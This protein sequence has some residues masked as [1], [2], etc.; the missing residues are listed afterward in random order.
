MDYIEKRFCYTTPTDLN[1]YYCG[2]RTKTRNHS[3]GPQV[4]DHF[5]LV[6]IKE[7]NATLTIGDCCYDLHAGQLLCMFPGEK[8]YYKVNDC[9]WSNLWV[10]VYGRQ[11]DYYLQNLGI[12]RKYPIFNCPQPKETEKIIDEIIASAEISNSYGK[13]KTIAKLYDFFSSLYDKSADRFTDITSVYDIHST[14]THEITYLSENIYIREAEN[15]IRFHYDSNISIHKLAGSLN[16]STE[17]FSRLFKSETGM[18]PQNML[19]KYR[20]EK[21]CK[22]LTTTALSINEIAHCVGVHDQRYFSK[23]FK[24]K[25]GCS[26]MEFRKGQFQTNIKK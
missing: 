20:L 16:L 2:K 14:D 19:I 10:G 25:L 18:T 3:Y 21:A 26:P 13:I 8:I 12:F 6:Y 7:G 23:L 9:L 5:L 24:L 22:L 1:M 17:Y 11:V 15:Y 4:R